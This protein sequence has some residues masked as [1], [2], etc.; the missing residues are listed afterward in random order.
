MY[1]SYR[2]PFPHPSIEKQRRRKRKEALFH[3]W[4]DGLFPPPAAEKTSDFQTHLLLIPLRTRMRRNY[5]CT[6]NDDLRKDQVSFLPL[7]LL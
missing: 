4:P 3:W 1:I 5:T 6:Q 7:A 2:C